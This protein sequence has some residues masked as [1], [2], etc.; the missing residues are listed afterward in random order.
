MSHN[1]SKA[2][3]EIVII[4]L[5]IGISG[6]LSYFFINPENEMLRFFI[7]DLVMTVVVFAFSLLK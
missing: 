4:Y 7:A 1:K 2:V 3:V 6:F 5:L